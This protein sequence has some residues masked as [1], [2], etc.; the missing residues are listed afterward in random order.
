MN[1]HISLNLIIVILAATN[2]L[3]LTGKKNWLT[4][5]AGGVAFLVN[6]AL[7]VYVLYRMLR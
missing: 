3:L 7:V 6:A 2:C 5:S 1:I 4:R